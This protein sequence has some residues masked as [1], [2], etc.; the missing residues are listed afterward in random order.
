MAIMGEGI[1]TGGTNKEEERRGWQWERGGR[2][3]D[4]EREEKNK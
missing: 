2:Q 1:I 4:G 3:N